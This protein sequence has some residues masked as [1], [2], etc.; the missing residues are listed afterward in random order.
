MRVQQVGIGI[1]HD[2]LDLAAVGQRHAGA[3]DVSQAGTD[4]LQ[5]VI[6]QVGLAHALATEAELHDGN[7]RSVVLDH[8]GW[9]GAR[10]QD[11]QDGL[12]NSGDLRQGKLDLDIRL[13]EDLDDRDALVALALG[14]LHVIDRGGQRALA[15]RDHTAFHLG[16]RQAGVGPHD[17]DDGN[18]DVG[19]NVLGRLH[20]RAD[21][22]KGNQHRQHDESVGAA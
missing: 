13:E 14:V 19:K 17:R 21:A 22:Q 12:H 15:H 20:S 3:L 16:G 11:A 8:K 9:I 7:R 4:E 18:V 10:R 2:L 1:H 6:I 5:A